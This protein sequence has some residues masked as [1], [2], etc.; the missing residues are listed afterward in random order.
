MRACVKAGPASVGEQDG[1]NHRRDA[2]LSL[3]PR[4]VNRRA[5]KVRVT[6]ALKQR[7][8]R[9]KVRAVLEATGAFEV[10]E[11]EE[12]FYG[13]VV[14]H[15]GIVSAA[16]PVWRHV[17]RRSTVGA[18]HPRGRNGSP[19]RCNLGRGYDITRSWMPRPYIRPAETPSG[20]ETSA[21]LLDRKSTRL[22]SSHVKIS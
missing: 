15:G 12:P 1:I 9:R 21:S 16:S 22:N 5:A 10:G 13:F 14:C 6:E 17:V 19:L 18:R 4:D 2:A 20:A 8:H 3:A 7:Q 11:R